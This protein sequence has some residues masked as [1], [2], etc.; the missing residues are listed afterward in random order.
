MV[1]AIA[2][3]LAL[4]LFLVQYRT[5]TMAWLVSAWR[6]FLAAMGWQND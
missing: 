3:D 4:L 1:I 6:W 2:V 5:E